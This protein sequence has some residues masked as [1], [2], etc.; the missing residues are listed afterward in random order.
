VRIVAVSDLHGFLPEI[1]ACDLLIVAGDVCPDRFGPFMAAHDPYQQQAWF[2]RKV[3]PWLAEAPAT[4]KLLTWCLISRP[5]VMSIAP[6]TWRRVG[7][8]R[9]QPRAARGD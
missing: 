6:S 9:R 4:H 5:T 7:R 1:P 3:R 2:D 8:T